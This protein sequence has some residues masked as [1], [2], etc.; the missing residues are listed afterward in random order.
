MISEPYA[1]IVAT[2]AHLYNDLYNDAF[3]YLSDD[4]FEF[5]TRLTGMLVRSGIH[6]EITGKFYQE[7]FD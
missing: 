5:F 4:D 7:G 3:G 2:L 1:K 6:K